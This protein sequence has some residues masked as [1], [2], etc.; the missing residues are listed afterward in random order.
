MTIFGHCHNVLNNSTNQRARS[1][2]STVL[3]H[4][5]IGYCLTNLDGRKLVTLRALETGK[6]AMTSL[7]N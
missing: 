6:I 3:V 1:T 5:K 4:I 7:E 2:L